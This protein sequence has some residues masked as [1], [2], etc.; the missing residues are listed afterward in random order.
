VD[1]LAQ[2]G[3]GANLEAARVY[4]RGRPGYAPEVAPWP[5]GEFALVKRAL[6]LTVAVLAYRKHTGRILR[7]T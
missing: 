1:P 4:E 7:V 3:F 6:W 2:R 5:V